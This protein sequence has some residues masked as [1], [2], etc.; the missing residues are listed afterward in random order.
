MTDS[1]PPTSND[2][3]KP[4]YPRVFDA[5]PAMPAQP[6]TDDG[7]AGARNASAVPES[8][9]PVHGSAP[10]GQFPTPH[11]YAA[12]PLTDPTAVAFPELPLTRRQAAVDVAVALVALL[13]LFSP[14]GS[15]VFGVLIALFPAL[16]NLFDGLLIGGV[17]VCTVALVLIIRRHW[18]RT[19]GLGG[20]RGLHV[21]W[22]L[23][24]IPA[25]YISLF[26]IGLIGMVVHLAV[27]TDMNEMMAE[28]QAFMELLPERNLFGFLLIGVFTGFHEELLFRGFL[29]SRFTAIAKNR[30]V[31]MLICAA[32][33][34]L[35]H[36]FGQGWLG[37]FQTAG[38]GAVLGAV[39]IVSRSLWPAVIAHAAFNSIQ[40][41]M[42]PFLE[43]LME[44]YMPPV[45]EP[46]TTTAP[47]MMLFAWL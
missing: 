11:A 12:I 9:E 42:F 1:T 35:L 32:I 18:P 27:G 15:I 31:A 19:I 14:V 46:G 16:E 29:L 17:T 8:S 28:R 5:R 25:C 39:T 23:A 13:F 43:K 20:L 3:D 44:Q 7:E 30:W 47:A 38:I 34:G 24:A 10:H 6:V 4:N 40:L 26:S 2:F 37:V 41:A 36:Y 33:F 22:A 21:L 45:G